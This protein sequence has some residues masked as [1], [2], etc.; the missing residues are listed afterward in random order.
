M[1]WW[2]GVAAGPDSIRLRDRLT[3]AVRDVPSHL[4]ITRE[5]FAVKICVLGRIVDGCRR[6]TFSGLG[7]QAMSCSLGED[8]GA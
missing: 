3:G 2:K 1:G 5:A 7:A 6:S 4:H 8:V